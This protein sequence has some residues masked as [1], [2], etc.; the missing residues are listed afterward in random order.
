MK[1][2]LANQKGGVGKTTLAILLTNHLSGVAN[3]NIVGIDYDFQSSYYNQYVSD[4]KILNKEPSYK[5]HKV[6]LNRAKETMEKLSGIKDHTFIIDSP[7]KI[8]D[9]NVLYLFQ[10]VDLIIAPFNYER[11]SFE[12]TYLFAGVINKLIPSRKI[13][14]VPNIVKATAKYS[15]KN[16]VRKAL[17][18][19]GEV[20]PIDLP[21]K[22]CM[23]RVHHFHTSNKQMV[24]INSFFQYI[25]KNYIINK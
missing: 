19:F 10:N 13:L 17:G 7:G 11:K 16:D 6:N 22:V 14:F 18:N 23:S 12:S 20:Y 8:D 21:D 15:I 4:A 2:L 9:S 24:V 1:I 3:N 25:D 5:V